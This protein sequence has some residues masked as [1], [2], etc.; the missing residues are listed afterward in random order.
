MTVLC[1]EDPHICNTFDDPRAVVPTV[2]EIEFTDGDE[3]VLPAASVVSLVI[4]R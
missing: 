2:K 3:V 4:K 1:S